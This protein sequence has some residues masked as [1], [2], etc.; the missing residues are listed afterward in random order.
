MQRK[1]RRLVD[2]YK[3]CF[4]KN[5]AKTAA[6]IPPMKLNVN[7]DAWTKSTQ[8]KGRYR[9]QSDAKHDEIE[10]QVKL[11]LALKVIKRSKSANYSHVHLVRKPE[12]KWRFCLDFRFLNACTEMEGGVLPMISEMLHRIGNRKPKFFAVIDFT[13]G[14]HQAPIDDESQKYTAFITRSGIYE[15]ARV[16]MGLKGAPSYFQ[17]EIANTVLGGLL[18]VKC[19]LY[20]DDLIIFGESEE[21]FCSNL[22]EVLAALEAKGITCNPA[23]CRFGHDSIEYV[24]HVI[25]S[26]GLNFSDDKKNEV[27][28]FPRPLYIKELQR[29]L[30]LVNYF[31][32]HVRDLATMTHPLRTLYTTAKEKGKLQWT[33][34]LI[35]QFETVKN[36]VADLPKLFFV[37]PNA[38]IVVYTDASDYGIGGYVCQL[39]DTNVNGTMVRLEHP[40][41]F[42]S[43][44]LTKTERNWTT[45]EKECY[46]IVHT[47]RKYEYLLRDVKFTLKTDHANLLYMNIPPSS[48]V[49]RWKLAIQE[50]DIDVFHIP[51]PDNIAA[52][53]FSRLMDPS[54]TAIALPLTRS[55]ARDTQDQSVEAS[56][57]AESQPMDDSN[58]K[59]RLNDEYYSHIER[60][61]NSWSGHRGVD[62]TVAMLKEEGVSWRGMVKHVR[63]FIHQC[64]ICQKTNN[65]S[66]SYNTTAY[67]TSSSVP[68]KRLNIDSFSVGTADENGNEF[69]VVIVDTCTR[70][71]ELHPVKDLKAESIAAKLIEHFGRFGPPQ[72][73]LTDQGT[74]YNNQLV[75][76]LMQWQRVSHLSTPIAHSHEQNSRVE[77]VNK[78]LKNHLIKYCLEISGRGYWSRGLPAVQF[79]IN[80]TRNAHTGY[81]P[82]DL[83]FGPAINPHQLRLDTLNDKPK[84]AKEAHEW[85]VEQQDLHQRILERAIAL[86]EQLD[87]D[88]LE[89]RANIPTSYPIGDYVLVGYPESS[90]TGSR[91]PPSKLLPFRKGPMKIMDVKGD[92]YEV[93]DLVSRGIQTV[94][95]SRLFPFWYDESRVDPENIA[96][97]DAEEYK[98]ERIIDDTIDE[99]PKRQWTFK[100]R[101]LGYDESEDTWSSW[102]DLK[103]VA[104]L[105]TYLRENGHGSAIPKSHQQLMDRKPRVPKENNSMDATSS[106]ALDKTPTKRKRPKG[107]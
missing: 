82:F 70:W 22:D 67:V 99:R 27:R 84:S 16:P 85:L 69:V 59:P 104:A 7:V 65:R 32:D 83:L 81:S 97:R 53:A 62:A 34:D 2:K 6:N 25:D 26:T 72:E 107:P 44:S 94:H 66:I 64:P 87:H 79:I 42:M 8:S 102:D 31:G 77:R 36:A 93:L 21:E 40:I 38:D 73:I 88:H 1:L 37:D 100:V 17:R 39:I 89:E 48:K 78:E 46:A 92:A 30:G 12:N 43:K 54:E 11:L 28:E 56:A 45:I 91:R 29:F 76:S 106:Q 105:H 60:F 75:E 19:E 61:H 51:G 50:Y 63:Q 96:L 23:K 33:D 103:D 35:Q 71:V 10:R 95:V 24:G 3:K 14:Y 101:W 90:F 20:L 5:V 52:D 86:Q 49:L 68:H 4:R 15:W 98:I 57:L 41:A 80:T 13:S 47:L 74:E 18:G 9:P 58:N 55:Q